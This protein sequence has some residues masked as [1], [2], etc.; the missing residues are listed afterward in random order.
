MGTVVVDIVMHVR[1]LPESGGDVVASASML[2]V[3]G[4]L[5]VMS[6]AHRQG[7]QVV[8]AGGHAPVHLATWFALR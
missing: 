8:Y 4:A 7:L 3:G 1:E 6:A 2:A 5:N